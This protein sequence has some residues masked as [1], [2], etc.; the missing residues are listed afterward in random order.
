MF[1]TREAQSAMA[2]NPVAAM[3]NATRPAEAAGCTSKP[4]RVIAAT[5]AAAAASIPAQ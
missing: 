3:T 1:E 4:T 5:V 2:G